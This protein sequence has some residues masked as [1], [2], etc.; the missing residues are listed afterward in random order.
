M[1]NNQVTGD[2]WWRVIQFAALAHAR[3][4]KADNSKYL[5]PSVTCHLLTLSHFLPNGDFLAFPRLKIQAGCRLIE[6]GAI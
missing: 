5:S 4:R 3:A 2:R 1:S 6:R